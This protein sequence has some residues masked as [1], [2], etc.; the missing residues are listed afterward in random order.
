M[1]LFQSQLD[2]YLRL[3]DALNV[4]GSLPLAFWLY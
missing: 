2:L 1:K 4:S 3:L